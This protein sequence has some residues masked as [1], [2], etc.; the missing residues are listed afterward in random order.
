MTLSWFWGETRRKSK[1]QKQKEKGRR[2]YRAGKEFEKK[3]YSFLRGKGF[4][5]H[6]ERIRFKGGEI[7]GYASKSGRHYAVEA[8]HTKQKVN[9]CVVRKLKKKIDKS[10]GFAKRG[11]I[12]SKSG[13]TNDAEREAKKSGIETHKYRRKRTSSDEWTW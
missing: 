9:V 4:K 1:K 13:F 6:K 8:K 3:A 10:A 7:D 5:V 11:V 2:S 12:V